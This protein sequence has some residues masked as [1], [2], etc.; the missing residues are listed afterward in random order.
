[1]KNLIVKTAAIMCLIATQSC[2]NAEKT[3][4]KTEEQPKKE[5]VTSNLLKSSV[6]V[7]LKDAQD[8]IVRFNNMCLEKFGSVPIRA[9]TIHAADLLEVL[10]LD[11][12]D[13]TKCKYKY[14][15][16]YL[17]LDSSNDFKLYLT[18]IDS[19]DLSSSPKKAGKDVILKDK[20]GSYVLDLNAPCPMTCDFTSP[21]YYE[22]TIKK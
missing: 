20:D 21:L 3:E 17:G 22:S 18:P 10:G 15:R 2:N 11:V 7:P 1:M 9:Y 13:T 4:T 12:S 19:A 14:A 6:R 5:A 16:A 8:N